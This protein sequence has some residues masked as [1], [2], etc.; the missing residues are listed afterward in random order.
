MTDDEWLA[1]DSPARMRGEIRCRP[2]QRLR[3]VLFDLACVARVRDLLPLHTARHVDEFARRDDRALGAVRPVDGRFDAV[4]EEIRA[5]WRQRADPLREARAAA[6]RAVLAVGS[7]TLS[8]SEMVC[9]AAGRRAGQPDLE[10]AVRAERRAH[11]AL[12]RCVFRSTLAPAAF[13]AAWRTD[14]V[15]ALAAQMRLVGD[16]SAVPIL[17]DALQDAGCDDERILSHCRCGGPHARGCWVVD[18]VL[19]RW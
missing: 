13:D 19:D 15:A 6:A 14:T 9:V 5:L 7:Q 4:R 12:V 16:Y 17:A 11:A 1:C 3:W 18:L 2:F 8:T 10:E